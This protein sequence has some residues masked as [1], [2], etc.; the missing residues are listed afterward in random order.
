MITSY[1]LNQTL[2]FQS[3]R[4]AQ[5]LNRIT[6][7][8]ESLPKTPLFGT[9]GIRGCVGV[10]KLLN[11]SLALKIGFW[12]GQTLQSHSDYLAPVILGQDPRNSSDMLSIAL[13]EGLT[14]AGLEVWNLGLCPT[15]AVAHLTSVTKAMGGIMISASHNPPEDNGIKFFG[16]DGTKLSTLIQAQIEAGIRGHWENTDIIVCDAQSL[17]KQY[18]R[19]ELLAQYVDAVSKPFG[20]EINL[21][22][23]R[24]VLDLAWGA[25]VNT[26]PAI[27][28]A[29]G[30]EVIT[31]H[32]SPDGDLINVNCGSTNLATLQQTVFE[33]QAD[34]GFAFD[35]DADR[36]M[37]VDNLGRVVDGDYILYLW[38]QALRK[39]GML[40]QDTIVATV[41]SNLGLENAWIQSG[42]KFIRTDVGDQ[43]VHAKMVELGASLGGEQ[44]GHILSP[45]YGVSGDGV[46]T[47]LH[48]STIVKQSGQT[49]AQMRQ[50]SFQTYPQLLVNVRVED[51]ESRRHWHECKPLQ[52]AISEAEQAMGTNG[53]VLVRPSG[54]E[55]V[56]RV[57]VEAVNM[58]LVQEWSSKLVN[59]TKQ[60]LAQ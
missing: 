50:D 40:S 8:I 33:H 17:G 55:P 5:I 48:L 28:R 37:A 10:D 26:A 25:A 38:G 35:G 12:A 52:K 14:A 15:P 16:A 36:L 20:T 51:P 57:M 58:E 49:L 34:L 56:I 39:K 59:C 31:I 6:R 27:F 30:A 41:M 42:G 32:D 7:N 23:M 3:P 46:L 13:S 19:P 21:A 9:D 43:H 29:M 4:Q 44:S 60:Y 53:R 47:A 22:G 18:Y 54:T 45:H 24:I 11:S 2:S 1:L